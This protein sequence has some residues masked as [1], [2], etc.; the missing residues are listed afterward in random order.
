MQEIACRKKRSTNFSIRRCSAN[1]AL[2]LLQLP[3]NFDHIA[4]YYDTLA[5]IV[6]G[7]KLSV[8]KGVFLDEIPA[9]GQVLLVGEGTGNLLNLLLQREPAL[10]ID[11]LDA[12]SK[13]IELTRKKVPPADLHRVRFFQGTH[14]NL[15]AQKKYD[16][17]MA[18]FVID[19]LQQGEAMAFTTSLT[20]ALKKEGCFLMAD[21]FPPKKIVH[22]AL[23]WMMYRFFRWVA[24]LNTAALPDYEILFNG[25]QL[26]EAGRNSYMNGFIQ[27]RFYRKI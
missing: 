6:F 2:H 7:N 9:S 23:L 1:L 10:T 19:C 3:A 18:F 4:P 24:D 14:H 5:T 20:N 17:V 11:Y 16:A 12:S 15:P 21:F 26:T 8:A 13:M 22:R 27:S 25:Q